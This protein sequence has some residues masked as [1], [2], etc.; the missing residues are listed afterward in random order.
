MPTTISVN[1]TTTTDVMHSGNVCLLL[2]FLESSILPR[3]CARLMSQVHSVLLR[4]SNKSNG[5]YTCALAP[6]VCTVSLRVHE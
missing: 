6:T 2:I 5:L 3:V 1:Q 4:R